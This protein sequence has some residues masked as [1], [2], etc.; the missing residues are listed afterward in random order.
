MSLE[1]EAI[2]FTSYLTGT[3]P[4]SDIIERY[5]HACEK[6]NLSFEGKDEKYTQVVLRRPFLLP[7]VDA[8]LAPQPKKTYLRKK[9][10]VML[11]ILETTT[12]YYP[13]FTSKNYSFAGWILIFYKGVRSVI[14]FLIGTIILLFI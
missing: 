3:R 1:K 2:I 5:V 6:L 9:I 11:A 13:V 10:W 8:A 14:K 12:A 4:S 7:F